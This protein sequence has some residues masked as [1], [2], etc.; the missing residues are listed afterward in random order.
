MQLKAQS[1]RTSIVC[2]LRASTLLSTN[3]L[4][5]KRSASRAETP[6]S[7]DIADFLRR[8]RRRCFVA[9][10]HSVLQ[11]VGADR[12]GEDARRRTVHDVVDERPAGWVQPGQMAHALR[13][14]M[15]SAGGV[16]ADAKPSDDLAASVV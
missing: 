16:T 7:G 5:Q 3:R 2:R 13:H 8:W 11:G 12:M 14:L 4:R 9:D 1:G 15:V 10:E 6:Q